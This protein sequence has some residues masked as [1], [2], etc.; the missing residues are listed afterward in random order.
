MKQP[1]WC[2]LERH[3][4]S[5]AYVDISGDQWTEF[6]VSMHANGFDKRKPIT[7][8]EGKILDGWQR[9]RACRELGIKPTFVKLPDGVDPEAFVEREN[10]HRRHEDHEARK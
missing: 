8:F 1:N 3:P 9:Y 4:L 7:L 5:A 2:T 6:V 10:D